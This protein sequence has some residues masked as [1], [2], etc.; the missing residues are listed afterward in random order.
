MTF[1]LISLRFHFRARTPIQFGPYASGN[2][3]RGILGAGLRRIYCTSECPGHSGERARACPLNASC[4]YGQIFEPS[5]S[6]EGPSGLADP[7]RPF[8]LRAAHL[9]DRAIAAGEPFWFD[10]NLF[11]TRKLS[12]EHLT[13]AFAEFALLESVEQRPIS[14]SL[15]PAASEVKRVRVEFRTPTQLK[16]AGTVGEPDFATLFA[17]L[18]DRISTLRALY[19][20]GPLASDFRRMR[21]RAAQIR[22]IGCQLQN[23]SAK[24][25]SS[26]TGQVH[27]IGGFIGTAEYEGELDEF[28]PYLEAARWT[29]VGRQCVWG[30]GEL[31]LQTA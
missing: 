8:V 13:R 14:L 19:G 10:I 23:I 12:I 17:R 27:S 21:E 25:R 22:T 26:R 31:A 20:S 24:R 1:D 5:P 4:P 9:D 28:V 18:Q 16:V 29:G 7:P 15:E 3:L 11:D 30:K 6:P 2:T